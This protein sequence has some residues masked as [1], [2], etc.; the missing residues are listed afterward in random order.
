MSEIPTRV[1]ISFT[2]DLDDVPARIACLALEAQ[3]K[4]ETLAARLERASEEVC[5]NPTEALQEITNVRVQLTGA[6]LWLE[7]CQNL[8]LN[9]QATRLQLAMEE[10]VEEQKNDQEEAVSVEQE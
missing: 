9:Y 3:T 8:L 2:V 10:Q 6:D 5:I 7:D 1:K 4:L